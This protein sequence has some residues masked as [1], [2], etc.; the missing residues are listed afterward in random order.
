MA[1]YQYV[2]LT[3]A[4][5][6]REQDFDTWYDTQHLADVQK[7]PGVIGARRFDVALQKVYDL[8]APQYRSLAIYEVETDDPAGFLAS[9]SALAGTEAMPVSAALDRAGMIQIL[10]LQPSG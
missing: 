9:I 5:P 7:V 8:D 2:V 4:L 6:G 3:H 1:R 10:A